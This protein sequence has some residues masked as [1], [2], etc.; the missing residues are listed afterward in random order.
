MVSGHWLRSLFS[1][2]IG[3]TTYCVSHKRWSYL[4]YCRLQTKK[5]KQQCSLAGNYP[6]VG[7][8]GPCSDQATLFQNPETLFQSNPVKPSHHQAAWHHGHEKRGPG[9]LGLENMKL[10][11]PLASKS[12]CPSQS[13]TARMSHQT[14]SARSSKLM[15]DL[16]SRKR[17]GQATA[18]GSAAKPLSSEA[19]TQTP[20]ERSSWETLAA[21]LLIP[22][23]VAR[24]S[25]CWNTCSSNCG[26]DNAGIRTGGLCI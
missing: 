17:H 3:V 5:W 10:A 4:E 20:P 18:M 2:R 9:L 11:A 22:C 23:Y 25:R 13:S 7:P 26:P 16:R 6:N 15:A 24:I 12:P 1:T 21:F 19:E 8:R 14:G